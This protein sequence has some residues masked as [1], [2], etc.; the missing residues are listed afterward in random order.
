MISNNTFHN[1]QYPMIQDGMAF[2]AYSNNVKTGSGYQA[3]GI[4]GTMYPSTMEERTL[5]LLEG[6]PYLA[7]GKVTVGTNMT[8]RLPA[9][10]VVKFEYQPYS[11]SK[12]SI[13]VSGELDVQGTSSAPVVFTSSLDDSEG[14]D[15]NDDGNATEPSAADWGYIKFTGQPNVT[16]RFDYCKVKYGG[17]N[18]TSYSSMLWITSSNSDY[19]DVTVD[20]CI[21]SDS[22]SRGIYVDGVASPVISNNTFHNC[23]YPMVQDGMAFPA[24]SNNVKTGS[25]YQAI[26]I[27][28]NMSPS[29]MEER[30]LALLDDWPYLVTGYMTVSNNMTLRLPAG[31]LLKFEYQSSSSGKRSLFVNGELDVQ[32]TSSDP[33]VFTSS[34]DD[35]EGGDTNNDGNATSPS[36]GDWGYIKFTGQPNVSNRFE[37]CNLKYGGYFSSSTTNTFTWMLWITSSDS[38]YS[39]ITV[40]HCT[41]SDAR[42]T[43]IYVDGVASPVISNNT[44]HNCQYPM[45]QDGMAFPAYSNNVKTGSGYQAIG[46]QGTMYPSTMEERTLALL[47]GWPYLVTGKVTV[48]TNMTLRLPAGLVVKF[49]YQPYSVSKPS[50]VCE[51]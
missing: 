3:I 39:D 26:G 49:E 34:L 42:R 22:Y 27:Q 14:G 19:S 1:C 20:H 37:Y 15:T 35:S 12:P 45:I 4:Q 6:W 2:P 43:G 8:L 30:T 32:G 24:Y 41:F 46:I 18:S 33:V 13:F 47:E 28:G 36:T 38:D 17:Y 44:F 9:G 7:T 40:D 50:I 25:G 10:L 29:T 31:L 16:N 48:G 21:F 11:V 5:A 51:R 23:Q